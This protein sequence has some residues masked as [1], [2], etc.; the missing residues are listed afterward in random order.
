MLWT[1]SV[2]IFI[3][4]MFFV[5]W[6]DM[7]DV[8]MLMSLLMSLLIQML[9]DWFENVFFNFQFSLSKVFLIFFKFGNLNS[10]NQ[11]PLKHPVFHSLFINFLLFVFHSFFKKANWLWQFVSFEL[12]EFEYWISL[13][14]HFLFPL[15]HS[16]CCCCL[17]LLFL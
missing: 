16:C 3:L 2:D 4:T 11:W 9:I 6:I 14:F 1:F 8:I 15:I 5:D 17:L 13:I 7:S 10:I 12:M